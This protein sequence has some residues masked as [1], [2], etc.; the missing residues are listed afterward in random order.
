MSLYIHKGYYKEAGQAYDRYA[1]S[2]N[3]YRALDTQALSIGKS[4][5]FAPGS[6]ASTTS[7][8][9]QFIRWFDTNHE[10]HA[11]QFFDQGQGS[12][13]WEVNRS[14][15][16]YA[17]LSGAARKKLD[18]RLKKLLGLTTSLDLE[19]S[20]TKLE[21]PDKEMLA[22]ARLLKK[23]EEEGEEEAEDDFWDEEDEGEVE[24]ESAANDDFWD[25][26]DTSDATSDD[27]PGSQVGLIRELD[28]ETGVVGP[29]G[30]VLI[31]FKSWKILWFK[32][33]IAKVEKT[34]KK[35][36]EYFCKVTSTFWV[37]IGGYYKTAFNGFQLLEKE[38]GLV[39]KS[40]EWLVEP[41][42][43]LDVSPRGEPADGYQ[44]C[45]GGSS[46]FRREKARL[47]NRYK[48]QGYKVDCDD[49]EWC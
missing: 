38:T 45:S 11:D 30:D 17:G 48:S 49:P 2:A 31:P 26:D 16:D 35:V 8:W 43:T 3:V 37:A 15:G 20:I 18:N 21:W 36:D 9:N 1:L 6:M 24:E 5:G 39:D 12:S 44:E 33:G 46:G 22:I 7:S 23:Y 4:G 13:D 10:T 27:E 41:E 28:G 34:G 32:N 40:G 47:I 14:A 25:S 19:F 42:L 29:S